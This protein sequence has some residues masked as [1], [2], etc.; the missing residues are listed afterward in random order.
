MIVRAAR[1]PLPPRFRLKFIPRYFMVSLSF[2]AV[3]ESERETLLLRFLYKGTGS[4]SFIENFSGCLT[5][6]KFYSHL[7]GGGQG[8]G[9]FWRAGPVRSTHF[10]L[11]FI[12]II[13]IKKG[14]IHMEGEYLP[15][16]STFLIYLL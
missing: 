3:S 12:L 7:L 6:E 10:V 4:P 13:I 16:E 14:G 2:C 9:L 15:C 1:W 5:P 8:P 11:L